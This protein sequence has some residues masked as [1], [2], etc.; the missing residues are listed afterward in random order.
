MANQAS[1]QALK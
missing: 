1:V